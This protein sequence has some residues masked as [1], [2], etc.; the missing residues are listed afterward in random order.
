MRLI[1][2]IMLSL[3]VGAVN[4]EAKMVAVATDQSE[5]RSSP[6]LT[7]SYVTIV[8]PRFYPLYIHETQGDFYK[9]SDYLNNIGWILKSLISETKGVIVNNNTVKIF[10]GPDSSTPVLFTAQNGVTFKVINEEGNW[11]QVEQ[12]NGMTGWVDRD[13]VWG[14]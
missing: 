7:K 2:A 8:A 14:Y 11:L 9:V 10:S 13:L 1:F 5:I 6:S 4:V 12:E 3:L